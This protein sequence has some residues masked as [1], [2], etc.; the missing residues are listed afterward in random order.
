MQNVLQR[1]NEAKPAGSLN[2]TLKSIEMKTTIILLCNL[3]ICN[4][5]AAQNITNTLGT[6]GV[7][8]IKE[9]GADYF[10]IQDTGKIYLPQ[11]TIGSRSGS[12]FKGT[13]RFLHTYH[14]PGTNGFNTFLGINAG[15][16]TMGAFS[17]Q[18]ASYNTVVG[19]SAL[20]SLT[21]GY[22]N[23]VLGYQSMYFNSTGYSNSSF[24]AQ[25]LYSN[26]SGAFNS[27]FGE[28]SLYSNTTGNS[29]STFG[30]RSLYLNTTGYNNSSLGS[31]SLYNNTS[32]Y[33]NS[34]FGSYSLLSNTTGAENAAFGSWSMYYNNS[35]HSNSAF[36]AYSLYF[37]TSGIYN[38]SFGRFS[39]YSNTASYNSA[40]GYYSLRYNTTGS[41]NTAIGDSSGSNITTGSNNLAIGYNSQ[42][43]NGTSSNQVRIGNTSVTYAG[44][45]VAWTITSDRKWKENIITSPLGL[46][47]ISR[48]NPVS[49][50]RINDESK[51]TEY[52]LIAQEVE[53]VLKDEEAENSA[54][55]TV[56]DEGNY[57][58][59]YNDLL[60]PLIKALQELKSENDALNTR[61]EQLV[62]MQNVLVNEIEKIKEQ[63]N[64]GSFQKINISQK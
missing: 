49:Y 52:G 15:N 24:G 47:F 27:S 26:T 16:F 20:F 28:Q 58:L 32:G 63:N 12:I 13:E 45:Q 8:T 44:V 25:S 7:F 6:S 57:E 53:E 22:S 35:G 3:L 14:R 5:L 18:S 4:F 19:N 38:S 40:F 60:A 50:T 34:A 41:F 39:L 64:S 37:N 36:G 43:P 11:Q 29:N 21:N 48:L 51:K 55:I 9:G 46:R 2:E 59:R 56:T 10:R 23:S 17:S 31:Q 30:E 42:V 54:M 1:A 33:N 62:K 61:I